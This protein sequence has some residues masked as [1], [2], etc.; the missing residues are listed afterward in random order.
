[1]GMKTTFFLLLSGVLSISASVHGQTAQARGGSA[2]AGTVTGGTVTGCS[3][4][5]GSVT[6]GTVT[7]GSATGGS[8]TAGSVSGGTAT[9]GTVTQGTASS[10][11][12]TAFAEGREIRVSAPG[13]VAVNVNGSSAEVKVAGQSL[14]VGRTKLTLDGKEL[15]DVPPD[16]KK[17][18]VT[19]E[20]DMLSIKGDG[21]EIARAKV[22]EP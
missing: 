10:G 20:K 4:T 13:S 3:A 5:G 18:E 11:T 12:A 1:M 6:G 21:K 8:A 9:P 15:G 2:T 16:T 7:G 19:L 22:A 17:V 14:T